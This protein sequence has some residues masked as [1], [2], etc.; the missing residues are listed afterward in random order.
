MSQPGDIRIRVVE[1]DALVYE[2]DVLVLKHAQAL[3][4]L[5][6]EVARR[7]GVE[8]EDL[9]RRDEFRI[10]RDPEGLDADSVIFVGV[11]SMWDFT[12]SDV[13]RFA[14]R[15]LSSVA[16]EIPQASSVALTLHGVGFG[17]DEVECFESEVAGILDA[18]DR[19]DIPRTLQR[20]DVVERD[21]ARAE[22]MQV[23]LDSLLGNQ[24]TL[25]TE[26]NPARQEG[27]VERLREVAS[28]G[29]E[30]P[31]AVVAMPFDKSFE[32]RFHYGMSKPIRKSG[33]LCERIDQRA[34]TGDVME[35]LKERIRTA[36]L[37]VADLTGSNANVFLEVGFAW[38]SDVPTVL[39]CQNESDLAF[40]VQ[41]QRCLIYDSI[42]EL[43]DKLLA[44]LEEL[45]GSV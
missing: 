20:I 15:A 44:E 40:D 25:T 28:E 32:D 24:S 43:E 21:S 38:G 27:K 30:K 42:K 13:R 7:L 2:T 8:T 14:Y 45:V 36:R 34:F 37:V 11:N 29:A 10:F 26:P 4:G 19:R 16:I 22:R 35:R 18:I 17:L 23:D 5:D 33:L 1:A 9:P 3:H 31:H 6:R 12:Y 39:V 41:G